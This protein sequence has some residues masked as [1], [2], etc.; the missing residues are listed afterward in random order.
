MS[1]KQW[2]KPQKREKQKK[3]N[4]NGIWGFSC[5]NMMVFLALTSTSRS[6]R[7]V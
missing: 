4:H 2:E 7:C 6:L 1:D 3:F 5:K